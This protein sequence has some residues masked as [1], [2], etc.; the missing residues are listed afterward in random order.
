MLKGKIYTVLILLFLQ[1]F[2]CVGINVLGAYFLGNDKTVD[3][4]FRVAIMCVVDYYPKICFLIAI[5]MLLIKRRIFLYALLSAGVI[6]FAFLLLPGYSYYPHRTLLLL[7]SIFCGLFGP[8]IIYELII[9][10]GRHR[11]RF[12]IKQWWW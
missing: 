2:F 6:F 11:N 8:F 4:A 1:I 5:L 12:H 10:T 3:L 7:V 9:A